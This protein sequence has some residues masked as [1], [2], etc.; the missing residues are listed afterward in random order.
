MSEAYDSLRGF[1]YVP[2]DLA[3]WRQLAA[4]CMKLFWALTA[5]TT[6]RPVSRD[7]FKDKLSCPFKDL[8]RVLRQNKED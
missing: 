2:C 8:S 6:P 1:R 4:R 3:D 5:Q 7:S